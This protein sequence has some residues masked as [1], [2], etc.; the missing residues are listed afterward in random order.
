L[1][2]VQYTRSTISVTANWHIHCKI[3]HQD[4]D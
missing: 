2:H 3:D 1:K 4:N